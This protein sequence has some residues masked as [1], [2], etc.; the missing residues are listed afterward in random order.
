MKKSKKRWKTESFRKKLTSKKGKKLIHGRHESNRKG[1]KKE[2]NKTA[3]PV[4]VSSSMQ[5]VY[6]DMGIKLKQ[7][8]FP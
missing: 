3:G 8:F 6:G 5:V 1:I 7:S 2:I 4:S